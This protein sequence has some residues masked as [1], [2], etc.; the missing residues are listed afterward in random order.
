MLYKIKFGKPI[1]KEL[2]AEFNLLDINPKSEKELDLLFVLSKEG[3]EKSVIE[4]F[5]TNIQIKNKFIIG[6]LLNSEDVYSLVRKTMR[7]LFGDVKISEQEIADIVVK[8]IIKR[9][10]I[11]SD[12]SKKAKKDIDKMY[13]RLEKAKSKGSASPSAS[14]TGGST[15]TGDA[16]GA[17][18][19]TND[20]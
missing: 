14:T 2:V 4:D 13:K 1:D 7:K 19:D 6:C 3:Q 8:D 17:D 5:Y 12:E 10:I 9:E 16:D 18:G 20:N 15:S 11:D